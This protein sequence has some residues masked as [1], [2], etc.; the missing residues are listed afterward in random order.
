MTTDE[1]RCEGEGKAVLFMQRDGQ[2]VQI[3]PMPRRRVP[4]L[5]HNARLAM[6]NAALLVLYERGLSSNEIAAL[7]GF[8]MDERT[9]RKSILIAQSQRERWRRE[10]GPSED[11]EVFPMFGCQPWVPSK[12]ELPAIGAD[13]THCGRRIRPGAATY[14]PK[15]TTTSFDARFARELGDAIR[16]TPPS[17]LPA[18]SK[19]EGRANS[20][21]A[22]LPKLSH[23]HRCELARTPQGYLWLKSIGQLPIGRSRKRDRKR[24]R[25]ARAC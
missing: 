9:V 16:R 2:G 17:A 5:A 3:D 4:I 22:P 1:T 25:T 11:P 19:L 20:A 18:Q 24:R 21:S 7:P 23:G 13:C 8:A 12:E 6:R 15:C 14:C 10:T